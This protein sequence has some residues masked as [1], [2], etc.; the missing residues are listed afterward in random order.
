MIQGL[1]QL[2]A[3]VIIA[4]TFSSQLTPNQQPTKTSPIQSLGPFGEPT[5]THNLRVQTVTL[6]PTQKVFC[7]VS[8]ERIQRRRKYPFDTDGRQASHDAYLPTIAGAVATLVLAGAVITAAK[9]HRKRIVVGVPPQPNGL[10]KDE[11]VPELSS[12]IVHQSL[13]SVARC[14]VVRRRSVKI[15]SRITPGAQWSVIQIQWDSR[16]QV[17]LI[18]QICNYLSLLIADPHLCH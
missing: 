4:V 13:S 15:A 5:P 6:Q 7:R 8:D 18:G 17:C 9:L 2:L 12:N 16:A 11:I 14:S 10:G 1:L 3:S